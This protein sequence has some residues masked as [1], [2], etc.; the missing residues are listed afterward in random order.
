MFTPPPSKEEMAAFGFKPEDFDNEAVEIWACNWEAVLLF[1]AVCTQ[2]R[3]AFGGATG[4]DYAAVKAVMDMRDIARERQPEIL[5]DIQ[6]M[7]L[8]ALAVMR[9]RNT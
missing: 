4:L 6:I 8:E 7:E 9:E 1:G 3:V 2:W 5:C